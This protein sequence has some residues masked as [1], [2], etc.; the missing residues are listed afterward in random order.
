MGEIVRLTGRRLQERRERWVLIEPLCRRCRNKSPPRIRVFTQ[1][2]HIVPLFKGG[3]DDDSN[4]QPLCDEC[5]AEKTAEDMG[6]V[7]KPPVAIGLDGFPLQP[8]EL[9]ARLEKGEP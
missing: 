3:P 1:L 7:G 9:R 6:Y 2:D 8:D 4:L 5:H